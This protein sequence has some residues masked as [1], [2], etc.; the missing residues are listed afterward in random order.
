MG[1]NTNNKYYAYVLINNHGQKYVGHT[2]NIQNRL[3]EHNEGKNNFTRYRK[4]WQLL[5]SET[6]SNK[7][8]AIKREKFFKSGKGREFLNQHI[9]KSGCSADG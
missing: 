3:N 1:L 8:D 4:P 2:V 5:Y 6:F 9:N 7:T